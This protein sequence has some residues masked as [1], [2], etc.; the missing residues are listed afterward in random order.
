MTTTPKVALIMGV[1]NKRSIAYSC[2][3]SFLDKGWKVI[4]TYQNQNI[5]SKMESSFIDNPQVLGGI[6]CDVA[7]DDDIMELPQRIADIIQDGTISSVLHS[8]AYAPDLKTTPLLE[9]SREAF[10]QAHDI[11]AYSL[12]SIAR[13]TQPLLETTT[14]TSNITAL[15]YLGA[16][17][18]I[19]GYNVM[20]PAKASLE[21]VV[22]GLALEMG[23]QN[24]R[25]NAVSAG[26]I[27]TISSKGGIANFSKMQQE[28]MDRSPMGNVS[29]EQVASTV[30]FLATEGT[31]ISGQTIHVDGGY[32]IVGGPSI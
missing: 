27:P 8:L 12:L 21:A 22:R 4:L 26:P 19:P 25:V 14:N 17:R 30:T 28:M 32:S 6:T 15:S 24:I 1:C 23:S 11:S 18:A 31:G 20:G 10:Q 7:Q 5:Q 2:A 3:Q 9:T 16:T 13:A 29:S